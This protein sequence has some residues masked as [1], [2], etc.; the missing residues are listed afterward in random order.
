MGG[1]NTEEADK[2]LDA[3]FGGANYKGPVEEG[4]LAL[5]TVAVTGADDGTTITEPGYTG[6]ARILMK[7]TEWTAA[8]EGKKSNNVLK[9]FAECTAGED[10]VIGWA[11][12]NEAATKKGKVVFSGKIPPTVIKAG[13]TPEFIIGALIAKLTNA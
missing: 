9:A 8:A 10:T 3:A 1:F 2:V 5:T 7:H 13:I 6:Y 12:C 11:W 4:Y